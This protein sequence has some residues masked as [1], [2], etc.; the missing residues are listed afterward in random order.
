[1]SPGGTE[2]GA[3]TSRWLDR[4]PLR[5]LPKW[6][7]VVLCN[8]KGRPCPPQRRGRQPVLCPLPLPYGVGATLLPFPHSPCHVGGRPAAGRLGPGNAVVGKGTGSTFSSPIRTP[9]HPAPFQMSSPEICQDH[10]GSLAHCLPSPA[11]KASQPTATCPGGTQLFCSLSEQLGNATVV[12]WQ[13]THS[14]FS[15]DCKAVKSRAAVIPQLAGLWPF[16][17]S[18]SVSKVVPSDGDPEVIGIQTQAQIMLKKPQT[19]TKLP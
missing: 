12:K 10:A 8:G 7:S 17:C 3:R 6:H 18:C 16:H 5:W 1:M 4:R 14:T 19:A 15:Y 9:A 11:D 2:G 13:G